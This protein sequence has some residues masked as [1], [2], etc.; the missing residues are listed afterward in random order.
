MATQVNIMKEFQSFITLFYDTTAKAYECKSDR[1][2]AQYETELAKY[3]AGDSTSF[4]EVFNY[5][6]KYL[7]NDGKLKDISII[8]F[9]DGQD[10]CSDK[11]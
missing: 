10:T 8:F 1:D 2:F 11:K 4:V 9:T 3:K 5:I 7:K 6:N